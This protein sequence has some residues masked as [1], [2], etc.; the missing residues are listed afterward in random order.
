MKIYLE[1]LSFSY[2]ASPPA[3]K[4]ISCTIEAGEKVALLG[5]NG[6]GKSTFVKHLG[7]LLLPSSGQVKIGDLLTKTASATSLAERVALLFQN[8]DDQI[9]KSSVQSEIAFGPRN[10]GFSREKVESLVACALEL[11]DLAEFAGKNPHDCGYSERKRIAMASIVAMDAPVLVFDEPT[12]GLDA[13]EIK[14]FRGA[15]EVFEKAGKTVVVISHDM[16]FVAENLTRAIVLAEGNLVYDGS[17]RE[18]FG[19][20]TL[21]ENCGLMLPQVLQL[22]QA[23]GID[24]VVLNPEEFIAEFLSK[25]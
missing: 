10:L 14:I 6:S 18:F 4:D 17:V 23:C 5:H 11:F 13:K 21:L 9:C 3:L 15:M 7:G 1:N 2:P 8:P 25:L 12:A 16:D 20:H 22:A 19:W 24:K